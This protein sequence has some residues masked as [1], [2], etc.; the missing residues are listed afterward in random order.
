MF[1]D[2]VSRGVAAGLVAGL[3][4]GLFLALVANPLVGFADGLAHDA[5]AGVDHGGHDASAGDHAGETHGGSAV[6]PAVTDSASVLWGVLWGVLLGGV[7]FGIAFFFLEPMLPG[8]GAAKSYF[9]GAAGFVTV[10]GAP[11]L[12]L[13]PQ[14]P[15]V[16]QA[17]ATDTRLMLYGGMMVLG[18]L[19]CLLAGFAYH[20]LRD[21]QGRVGAAAVA[22]LPFLGLLV[23]AALAPANTVQSTVPPALATGLTWLIVLSQVLLWALL[24][25]THQWL[26]RRSGTRPEA[27]AETDQA[28]AEPDLVGGASTAD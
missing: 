11:W 23:P 9:L 27:A 7:V 22:A 3:V 24:A 13:P 14:P 21:E 5:E 2:Y 19:A 20:R 28:V 12:V 15:G 4:F 26:R 10:S 16:E 6:S 1:V 25:G 18:A 8:T 17:L